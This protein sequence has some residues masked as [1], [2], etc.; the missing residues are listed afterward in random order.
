M[1]RFLS[2][3]AGLRWTLF[4]ILV[5]LVAASIG[6]LPISFALDAWGDATKVIWALAAYPVIVA[7]MAVLF[8]GTHPSVRGSEHLE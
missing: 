1:N 6:P 5:L 4:G 2:M 8:L 3:P 7:V